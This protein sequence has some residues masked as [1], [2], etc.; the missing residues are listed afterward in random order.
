M[1]TS[2]QFRWVMMA[3]LATLA[4]WVN[5]A[6][7]QEMPKDPVEDLRQALRLEDVPRP[8]ANQIAFRKQNLDNKINGLRTISD[9]R[10]ALALDEWKE[11]EGQGRDDALRLIDL[12]KRQEVGTRLQTAVR[13]VV[14]AGQVNSRLALAS[15]IAEMG[16]AVRSLQPAD[17]GGFA[18]SLTPEVIQLAQDRDLAVRLQGL[19]ALGTINADPKLALPVFQKVLTT[20]VPE[21]RTIAS[22]SLAQLMRVT[23]QLRKR[24]PILQRPQ[25][26]LDTVAMGVSMVPLAQAAL[27]DADPRV[28]ANSLDAIQV[29]GQALTDMIYEPLQ[30]KLFPPEG[31]PLTEAESADLITTYETIRNELDVF[32]PLSKV[33]QNAAPAITPLLSEPAVNVR[34]AG[35]NALES[36]AWG[37]LKERRRLENVPVPS[38]YAA[39]LPKSD[40]N[41]FGPFLVKGLPALGQLLKDPDV[42][43]RRIT[44]SFIENIG[45]SAQPAIPMLVEALGDRDRF[46]RWGSARVLANL[47]ADKTQAAV[48]RLVRLLRDPDLNVRQTAA[49]TLEA[50]GDY[51]GS[52]ALAV[53]QDLLEGDVD[54]RTALMAVLIRLPLDKARIAVP[55]LT[56][57]LGH[58]EARI[59]KAAA[60]TL[61][62]FGP[63][64][65]NAVPSLRRLLGDDDA[66][67]R[68]AA[69]D[70]ILSI[71]QKRK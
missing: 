70:A 22:Q 43:I 68:A 71:L 14:A 7:T 42:R 28:Q 5:S 17:R 18:R 65:E 9:L 32:K 23:G 25:A 49:G 30:R 35:I 11:E 44:I 33:L 40:D 37:I 8:N 69:S 50:M 16:P 29:A 53:A 21:A 6:R 47:P 55:Q 45:A 10:R 1:A 46:V 52:A 64:A 67:V 66:E 27:R 26:D 15:M 56:E 54:E 24:A 31:R 34:L 39:K 3:G 38:S 51:A 61:G 4:V 58:S 63:L 13:A 41:P 12:Q 59:R 20:D 48:P 60:E 36:I 19:R 57:L 2:L 62:K